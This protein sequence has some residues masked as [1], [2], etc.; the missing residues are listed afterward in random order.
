MKFVYTLSKE[1]ILMCGRNAT[2]LFDV[3]DI[4]LQ[5]SQKMAWT[6]QSKDG[7]V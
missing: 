6:A 7:S 5:S 3:V 4:L 2:L 1:E